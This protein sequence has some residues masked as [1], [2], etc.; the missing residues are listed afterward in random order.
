MKRLNKNNLIEKF[1]KY[2]IVGIIGTTTHIGILLWLVEVFKFNHILASTVGFILTVIISYC[3]NYRWTFKS[4]EKHT[5]ALL[6]YT[7]VSMI[8]LSLNTCIMFLSVNVFGLWYL[9]G[10]A[11]TVLIIPATNFI[12]NSYWS[13]KL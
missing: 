12:L 3:L 6:R 1:S 4:R 9:I 2:F 8:G 11:I 7:I 13:F 5:I 10:Q